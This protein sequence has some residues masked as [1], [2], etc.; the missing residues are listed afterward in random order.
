MFVWLGRWIHHARFTV[1]AGFVLAIG[2]SGLFGL[3]YQDR[4]SAQGYFDDTSES[5]LGT[6]LADATFGRDFDGDVIAL[7]STPPG[8]SI[9]D[10]EIEAAGK[11]LTQRLLTEF[12]T[13]IKDVTGYWNGSLVKNR[14]VD[15]SKTHAFMSIG[16]QGTGDTDSVEFYHR[17]RDQLTIPGVD[18]QV[19]GRVA[20]ADAVGLTLQHDIERMHLIALPLVAIVLF[21]V[22]GGVV[23]AALPLIIGGLTIAGSW[24]VMRLLTEIMQV[25]QF[26]DAVIQLIG[27]GLAIDYG[28][29]MVSRFREEIAEG[30]TVEDAVRTA[31]ATAGRTITF[32]AT[33]IVVCVAGV[34]IFPMNFLRSVALGA[35]A[36]VILAAVLSITVLPA[37]L[38]VLG[39]RVDAFGLKRFSRT[40]SAAQIDA[41]FWSRLATWSMRRPALVAYPIIAVLLLLI[42]P[43][44]G[45]EFTGITEKYLPPGNETRSAQQDFDTIFP[46]ERTNPIKLVI[47]G[48]D[49]QITGQIVA[50]ADRTPGLTGQFQKPISAGIAAEGANV[51]VYQAGLVDPSVTDDVIARLRSITPPAGTTIYVT[52]MPALERDSIHGITD[53]LPV[54]LA[55]LVIA[56]FVMMFL[57]FG[58]FVLPIKATVVS[59]LSLTAALG[60]LAYVFYDGHGAGLLDFTPQPLSFPVLVIMIAIIFGLS[61]DYE[62]FLMSRM[63]EARNRGAPTPEAIRYGTAHTGGI[64]TAAALVLIVVTGAFGLSDLVLMKYIAYGMIVALVLDATIIRMLLVPAIMRILGDACWWAPRWAM[65]LHQRIGLAEFETRPEPAEPTVTEEVS[66]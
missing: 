51:R 19:A 9:T 46:T 42:V 53:R 58:S 49:R 66:L 32:S 35:L 39:R 12:R 43:F 37:L 34:L 17:I 5:V 55:I 11:A 16:L 60:F 25:N 1:I 48:A 31:V 3:G 38:C 10:P 18:V 41:S 61:T 21:F 22:F 54:L 44:F 13:E 20:V 64:I 24:G 8:R 7:F 28:L 56:S 52:G 33:I 27:L 57:A 36:A 62:I 15:D 2:L 26:A 30:R 59:G 65:R 50:A 40:T 6:K 23:A 29:F 47:T 63:A 45:V 14:F 4:L